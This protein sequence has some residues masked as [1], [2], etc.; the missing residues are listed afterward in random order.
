MKNQY[1]EMC[2]TVFKT[3]F[4]NIISV[5]KTS[6]RKTVENCAELANEFAKFGYDS[7]FE[8]A[9]TNIKAEKENRRIELKFISKEGFVCY[10]DAKHS[11]T[12]SNI[13]DTVYGDIKRGKCLDGL[14]YI[15]CYGTGYTNK[16]INELKSECNNNVLILKGDIELK[17]QLLKDKKQIERYYTYYNLL[18]SM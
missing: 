15:V 13:T 16:I 1:E 7:L 17:N 6:S 18:K 12:T 2:K 5:N 4:P 8:N 14:L 11:D 3:V 10:V 9:I